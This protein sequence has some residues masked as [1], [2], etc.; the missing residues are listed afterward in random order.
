MQ[1]ES[2]TGVCVRVCVCVCVCVCAHVH[3]LMVHIHVHVSHTGTGMVFKVSIGTTGRN[4]GGSSCICG[5]A[6]GPQV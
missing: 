6:R 2:C 3:Q 4:D 1:I 5:G